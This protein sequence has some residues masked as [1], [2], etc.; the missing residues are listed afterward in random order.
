MVIA[1]RAGE[2]ACVFNALFCPHVFA[3]L[4]DCCKYI[5]S[6]RYAP[7]VLIQIL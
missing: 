4:Q 1:Y 5:N 3:G 6:A 7:I 2:K